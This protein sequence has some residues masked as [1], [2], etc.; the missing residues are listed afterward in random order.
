MNVFLFLY[1]LFSK[2][3][4]YQIIFNSNC[5]AIFTIDLVALMA[6]EKNSNYV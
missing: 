2:C 1:I 3:I 6:Y 5:V 4:G